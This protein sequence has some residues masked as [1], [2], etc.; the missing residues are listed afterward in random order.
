MHFL[1][2][3][4]YTNH[5][6]VLGSFCVWHKN[7]WF[8]EQV[9]NQSR[10]SE[11]VSCR[12]NLD[13]DSDHLHCSFQTDLPIGSTD[14]LESVS[15]DTHKIHKLLFC[16]D[17][18]VVQCREMLLLNSTAGNPDSYVVS[19]SYVRYWIFIVGRKRSIRPC[20]G[21][22]TWHT[23]D[24]RRERRTGDYTHI[25]PMHWFAIPQSSLNVSLCVFESGWDRPWWT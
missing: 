21:W 12:T 2:F 13:H 3:K 14:S 15:L 24:P 10:F 6:N 9:S 5:C 23:R 17:V 22:P 16:C 25:L 18:Y 11:D 8:S 4:K 1:H 7:L 20:D 19:S